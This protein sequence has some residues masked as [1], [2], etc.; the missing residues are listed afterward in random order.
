MSS[1]AEPYT[2]EYRARD[3]GSRACSDYAVDAWPARILR[4]LAFVSNIA[5]EAVTHI[6]GSDRQAGEVFALVI[7]SLPGMP[8]ARFG[9]VDNVSVAR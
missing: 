1:A 8:N 3:A 9:R 4:P 7:L 2:R 5:R 6:E